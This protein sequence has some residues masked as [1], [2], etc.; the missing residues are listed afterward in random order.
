[1]P[2]VDMGVWSQGRSH[3]EYWALKTE[4]D[5]VDG[6]ED[7][8][9]VLSGIFLRPRKTTSVADIGDCAVPESTGAQGPIDDFINDDDFSASDRYLRAR[10]ACDGRC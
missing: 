7:D 10:A 2:S 1:M 9:D 6:G 5:K 4:L 3:P 8:S